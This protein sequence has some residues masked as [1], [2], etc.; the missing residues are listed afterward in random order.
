MSSVT[1]VPF[2]GGQR[3]S[4]TQ[5][6]SLEGEAIPIR[7]ASAARRSMAHRWPFHS[8]EIHTRHSSATE[9]SRTG[10]K[11]LRDRYS[12]LL[13]EMV[14]RVHMAKFV[15]RWIHRVCPICVKEG[16]AW[17]F[18]VRYLGRRLLEIH[19]G[20]RER[21]VCGKIDAPAYENG[22][23]IAAVKGDQISELASAR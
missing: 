17:A 12:V 13:E 19:K 15:L 21:D 10:T 5:F 6:S 4:K 14:K 18:L 22:A 8:Y 20:V 23:F 9:W 1:S 16:K 7:N 11:C 3:S 2:S